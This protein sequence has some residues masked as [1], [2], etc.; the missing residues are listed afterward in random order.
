MFAGIHPISSGPRPDLQQKAVEAS[1]KFPKLAREAFKTVA[2]RF[3]KASAQSAKVSTE[4]TV[5]TASRFK[6]PVAKMPVAVG[7]SET[8]PIQTVEG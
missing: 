3:A 4:T 6:T 7:R 8:A 1:A 2:F 5:S